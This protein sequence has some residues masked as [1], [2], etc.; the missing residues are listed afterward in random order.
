MIGLAD[1]VLHKITVNLVKEDIAPV[2]LIQMIRRTDAVIVVTQRLSLLGR[3]FQGAGRFRGIEPYMQE[4]LSFNTKQH[5]ILTIRLV[6]RSSRQG[7]RILAYFFDVHQLMVLFELGAVLEGITH[8]L[9]DFK[10]AEVNGIEGQQVHLLQ[11]GLAVLGKV[12]LVDSD[13]Q[14]LSHDVVTRL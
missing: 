3:K 5:P 11:V 10:I 9:A 8:T 6:F 12:F 2:H 13:V 14:N 7:Q 1:K 4:Y